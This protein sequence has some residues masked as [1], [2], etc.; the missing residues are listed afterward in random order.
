M[1]KARET[2]RKGRSTR[3]A[4]RLFLA[5]IIALVL[6][7][8]LPVPVQAQDPVDLVLGGEG[9]TPWSIEDIMPCDSGTK[10]VT[11][12]NAGTEKSNFDYCHLRTFHPRQLLVNLEDFS[13]RRCNQIRLEF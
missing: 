7:G 12:H 6:L 2:K 4:A 11:L 8:S 10:T 3:Y 1:N 9:A 5:V 13:V